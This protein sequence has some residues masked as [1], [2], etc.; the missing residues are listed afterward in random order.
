MR[1][2]SLRPG[3]LSALAA[4]S[5]C[6]GI[7]ERDLPEFQGEGA[8]FVFADATS[9]LDASG[10]TDAAGDDARL[11]GDLGPRPDAGRDARPPD[12]DG[13]CSRPSN[14]VCNGLDDDCNGVVD[15]GSAAT[16]DCYSGPAE[17]LNVGVCRGGSRRCV[18]GQPGAC[19]GEITP[20]AEACNG[21]DDDC[22][23]PTDEGPDGESLLEAC[24][25]GD[26]STA[27]VGLCLAGWRACVDGR[28][29]ACQ[30]QVLPAPETCDERD[31]DCNGAIDDAPEGCAC[32]R[33]DDRPCYPGPPGTAGVGVCR[34]GEQ[35]CGFRR[36]WGD[37]DG[38]VV[39]SEDVC[40]GRDDD[41]DGATDEGLVDCVPCEP[42]RETCNGQD[43][44]CDGAVDEGTDG[45]ACS[46]GVGACR[47]VGRT[48][49]AAGELR[50]DAVAGSPTDEICN[51][52]D[53]DCDGEADDGLVGPVC[54]AGE[55]PCRREGREVCVDGAFQC[56]V[57][58]RSP[59]PETCNGIDDDC[60]GQTDE[61][62]P[63]L[64]RPCTVGIGACSRDGTVI[65][66][67]DGGGTLC[68]VEP[69]APSEE[70][71]DRR[72]NDCDGEIDEG[73]PGVGAVCSVGTGLCERIG[74]MV[75][76][77]QGI[78][79]DAV[80]GEPGPEVC[81]GEDN[82]CDGAI[83]EDGDPCFTP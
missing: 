63:H 50:C 42:G 57:A 81:D 82:D 41:C 27:G 43:D 73:I 3:L 5:G 79:C 19:E 15:D 59:E 71:C 53:D 69:G 21:A 37:C 70:V 58:A 44:D 26:P 40:N 35:T 9:P 48:V 17:T 11:A 7:P 76:T 33:G 4:L 62:F 10:P 56:N 47:G 6:I 20:A 55:G 34:E 16:L 2:R 72:D 68:G 66:T 18:G 60:N 45:D 67:A 78:G 13:A 29:S 24:Y 80:P 74:R 64:A 39:P 65:C 52:V 8:G 46:T 75:C 22:D 49:C 23:G 51:G 12:P 25:E 31:E 32:E 36:V 30:G 77:P 83:D 38:A 1:M 54:A 14:E 28:P 61:T